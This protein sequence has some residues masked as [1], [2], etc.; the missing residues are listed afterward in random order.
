MRIEFCE[1]TVDFGDDL[2]V[3]MLVSLNYRKNCKKDMNDIILFLYFET[4]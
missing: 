2:K 4:P 3:D 1:I